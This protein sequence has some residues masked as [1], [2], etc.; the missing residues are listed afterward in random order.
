MNDSAN[1]AAD[2]REA[3]ESDESALINALVKVFAY[4]EFARPESVSDYADT[5]RKSERS[6]TYT[7]YCPQSET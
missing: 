1:C 3:D 7:E 2:K 4:T 5:A 6:R